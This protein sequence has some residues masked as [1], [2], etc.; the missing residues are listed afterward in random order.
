M[1]KDAEY[2]CELCRAD[3]YVVEKECDRCGAILCES[4]YDDNLGYCSECEDT[5]RRERNEEMKELW[6]GFYNSRF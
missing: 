1:K 3:L 6:R 5:A 2:Q 4:C